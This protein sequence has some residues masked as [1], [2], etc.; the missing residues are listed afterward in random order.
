MTKLYGA[1]LGDMIGSPYEFDRGDKTKEFPLFSRESRFTDDSVMTIAVADALLNVTEENTEE[2][3]LRML[4]ESMQK[5]GRKYPNAGY[6]GRFIHWVWAKDPQPYNSCGNGS[7]MRVSSA[8]WLF[9]TLE[10]TRYYAKLSAMVSHNHPE[11]IKGA[12]SIASAIWMARNGY[13]KEEIKEYIIQEFHYDLS[14]TLDEIRPGYH[15][16]EICQ[17]TVPEALTAFFEGNDFEDVI[18]NAVSLSGDCDTVTCIAGA[19]AEAFYGVPEF[20]QK[21]C[22][23]RIG[24]DMLR[25]LR[26]INA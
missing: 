4:T 9:D 10:K 12:E 3:V 7:A 20:M 17:Q 14:R 6:G 8:G 22:E 18:R 19:V 16:V 23:K 11:G 1:L 21:E 25:V 15:H 5:W 13:S 24:R 26:R 2:E